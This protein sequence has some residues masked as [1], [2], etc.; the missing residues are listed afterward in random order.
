MFELRRLG[1]L[2]SADRIVVLSRG[3]IVEVQEDVFQ[4]NCQVCDTEILYQHFYL[5]IYLFRLFICHMLLFCQH[6]SK[7]TLIFDQ[8]LTNQFIQEGSHSQL[9]QKQVEQNVA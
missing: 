9:M 3:R 2:F 5:F 4:L 1:F 7:N 6:F 8:L